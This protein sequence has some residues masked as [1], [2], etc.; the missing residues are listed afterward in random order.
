MAGGKRAKSGEVP[1]GSHSEPVSLWV[2]D[3]VLLGNN[4]EG[5]E[6]PVVTVANIVVAAGA[7]GSVTKQSVAE[8]SGGGDEPTRAN[9]Y[10]SIEGIQGGSS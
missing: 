6:C 7:E 9:A 1:S 3:W 5:S 2:R 8:G 10:C 4:I